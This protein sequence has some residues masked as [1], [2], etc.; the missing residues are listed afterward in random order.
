ME[1]KP[2]YKR[3]ITYILG[4]IGCLG[5]FILLVIGIFMFL[6]SIPP[7]EE[8]TIIDEP[9]EEQEEK[10]IDDEPEEDSTNES[11]EHERIEFGEF[12]LDNIKTE[13]NNNELT[14]KFEWINQSGKDDIPFTGV[15]YVDVTQGDEILKETSGA[16]DAMTN[17][18][19]LRKV[20]N[21]LSAF[22]T[23]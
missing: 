7:S 21:G 9:E 17:S 15:G 12:T 2:F 16:Y 1:K 11:I 14:L 20:K 18:S 13:I 22:T 6:I 5:L 23:T 10:V 3:P 19:M 4:G 8:V